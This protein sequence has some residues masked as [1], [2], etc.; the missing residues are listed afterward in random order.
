MRCIDKRIFVC[1]LCLVLMMPL[2]ACGNTKYDLPYKISDRGRGFLDKLGMTLGSGMTLG[3]G[4]TKPV[5]L[6]QQK[7]IP[8]TL[9]L[10]GF[11]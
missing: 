4:M 2:V 6:K 8:T 9:W 7:T 1:I 3:L 5:D 11:S 10:S